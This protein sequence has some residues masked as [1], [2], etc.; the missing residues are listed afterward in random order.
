ML[1][2][3]NTETKTE[4]HSPETKSALTTIPF[5]PPA[6]EKKD[7]KQGK[8]PIYFEKNS[9]EKVFNVHVYVD[10]LEECKKDKID[11]YNKVLSKLTGTHDVELANEIINKGRC[12]IPGH[13]KAGQNNV[14][15][16]SLADQEPRDAHEARLCAQA[17]VLYSQ[18]MEYLE[19]AEGVLFNDCFDKQGWNQIFMK[20]ATRLLDLHTKTIEALTRY[21][22]KGEQ[23]IV[24]QHINVS[25]NAKAIVSGQMIAGGGGQQ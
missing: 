17:T 23:R 1:N 11:A 20:N 24:V 10:N 6:T 21:R 15:L 22:Q 16:Q 12:C 9:D 8:C 14:I 2:M 19:R 18:S 4:D 25:D 3:D 13:D 7:R 5:A